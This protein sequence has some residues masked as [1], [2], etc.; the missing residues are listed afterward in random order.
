MT[1][2][3]KMGLFTQRKKGAEGLNRHMPLVFSKL[4]KPDGSSNWHLFEEVI[5]WL[6]M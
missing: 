4:G 1:P 2:F 5:P 6:L 3:K